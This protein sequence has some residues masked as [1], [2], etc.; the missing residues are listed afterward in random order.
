MNDRDRLKDLLLERSVR[1]GNYTLASGAGSSYYVDA[2][3]TTMTA[4][5]QCLVG[6]LGLAAIEATDWVPTHVGGMTLGADPI[7]YAIAHES[8]AVGRPLDAFTVRKSPKGHGTGQQ[9]E[10]GLPEDATVV[11]VED[12]I[13]TGGSTLRVIEIVRDHGC[14]IAGVLSVIDR[15]EGAAEALADVGIEMISLFT[16][17]ELKG[18]AQ[19]TE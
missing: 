4:E 1:V 2:R 11:V 18:A 3:R 6:R 13:T 12:S 7:S 10:G 19:A 14:R 5:G 9:I 8:F 16:G 17:N 15:E